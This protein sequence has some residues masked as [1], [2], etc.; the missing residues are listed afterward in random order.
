MEDDGNTNP[1]KTAFVYKT[2]D[3]NKTT[4]SLQDQKAQSE[5]LCSNSIDNTCRGVSN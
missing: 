2:G 4:T 1:Y 3:T 5:S